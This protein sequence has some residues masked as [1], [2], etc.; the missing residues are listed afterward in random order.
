MKPA[1]FDH[2]A[3]ASI[4]DAVAALAGHPGAMVIAGG[5]SLLPAMNFRLATPPALIDISRIAELKTLTV[6]DRAVVVGAMV[7]HRTVELDPA[8]ARAQPLLAAALAH[9]AHVPIRNRG[10][11][12]GSLCHADASAEMPLLLLLTDGHMVVAGP[13][14][15]RT[16]AA[17]DFFRFHLTT[18]RAADEIALEAHFPVLPAGAGWAFEEVAR[19]SGDFALASVGVI[20]ERAADGTARKVAI[21]AGGI[22]SRP[23]RLTEAENA[24]LGTTLNDETV[25][26]AAQAAAAAVTAPGDIH[27]SAPCAASWWRRSSA[28]PSPPHATAPPPPDR[29]RRRP[30]PA[31]TAPPPQPPGSDRPTEEDGPDDPDPKE[32]GPRNIR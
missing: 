16:I 24:L 23:I 10:T 5:Q 12:V 20:V 17:A 18:S 3:P 4:A 1:L 29:D 28:R 9:V 32:D 15:R 26:L 30:P 21:A 11:V 25:E 14:G 19:R 2:V 31:R 22:A 27:A 6:T 13:T 7:R 8:V